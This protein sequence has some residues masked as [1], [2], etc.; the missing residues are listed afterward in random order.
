MILRKKIK[1]SD[2][3]HSSANPDVFAIDVSVVA[4]AASFIVAGLFLIGFSYIDVYLKSFG[5]SALEINVTYYAAAARGFNVLLEVFNDI[6]FLGVSGDKTLLIVGF[7]LQ[8]I[9]IVSIV[10][11]ARFYF[12]ATGW[13]LT[14]AILLLGTCWIAVETGAAYATRKVES[15]LEDNN[16]L[17]AYCSLKSDN[18]MDGSNNAMDEKFKKSFKNKSESGKLKKII[19]T[20]D[21][22][23][24]SYTS[25]NYMENI[26]G[27]SIAIKK[28][29]IR[30]CRFVN[31]R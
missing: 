25:E 6:D 10:S 4:I 14:A 13:I 7:F 2:E 21:M 19:E 15:I 30:F 23:Y 12:S 5:L 26:H 3:N 17:I 16:G 9:L 18:A 29:D 24:F 22:I 11:S 27:H 28:S 31:F 1:S 8:F 20:R